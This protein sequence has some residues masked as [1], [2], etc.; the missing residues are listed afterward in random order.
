MNNLQ[1][2]NNEQFGEIRTVKEGSE[3]LF[4]AADVCKALG[5]NDTSKAVA[6]LDDDEKGATSIPTL[7]G[8]QNLLTVNEY[9]LYSLVLASRKPEAKSFKRWITHEVIPAIR[10][11]GGYLTPQKIEEVLLNPDTIIQLATTLKEEQAK[12]QVAEVLLEEQK[13]KVLFAEA[14]TTSKQS[15]LVGELAKILRQNGVEVGQNRLF[16][17]LRSRGYLGNKGEQYNL[18]TQKS[19]ELGVMEIKKST[20]T[21][22]DGSIRVTST[23]K[24]T[25]KGQ[26]Y[27]INKLLGEGKQK[28]A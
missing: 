19:M 1:V 17:I 23:P 25:G 3:V 12:R 13:P 18:P 2:F 21:Q 6:R 11:H 15:C 7:G 8:N 10:Q 22:P 4:V 28:G 9:G 16:E 26:L 27:F 24:I 20:I 5:L 14:V